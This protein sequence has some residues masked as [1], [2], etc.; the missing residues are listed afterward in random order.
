MPLV[1]G[2]SKRAVSRNISEL[3]K[4]GRP[5]RQAVAIAMKKAGKSQ[6]KKKRKERG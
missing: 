1:R 2:K 4:S 5:Q 6:K 3:V